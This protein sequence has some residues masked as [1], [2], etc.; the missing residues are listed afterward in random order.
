MCSAVGTILVLEVLRG[1]SHF[2][3]FN[4]GL[5]MLAAYIIF[6]GMFIVGF[7]TL[8]A[9]CC[10]GVAV[11]WVLYRCA[12]RLAVLLPQ[13]RKSSWVRGPKKPAAFIARPS[14]ALADSSAT[15]LHPIAEQDGWSDFN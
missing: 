10:L 2:P 12:N 8:F 6:A 9:F 3:I 11:V 15:R 14:H 13:F 5:Q 7:L 1:F 4:R